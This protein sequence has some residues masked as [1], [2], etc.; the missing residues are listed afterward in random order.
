MAYNNNL[1]R[2]LIDLLIFKNFRTCQKGLCVLS[3][4]RLRGCIT[5]VILPLRPFQWHAPRGGAG[6]CSHG[7]HFF[8]GCHFS[9]IKIFF[10][11]IL[12][13]I[14]AL[15]CLYRLIT[16]TYF[17][18]KEYSSKPKFCLL[19]TITTNSS[20]YRFYKVFQSVPMG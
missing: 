20:L 3:P 8:K 14:F 4:P 15:V 9:H 1:D 17:P 19:R 12:L 7:C 16:I 5:V 10:Y 6:Q 18:I 11:K 2:A 13:N